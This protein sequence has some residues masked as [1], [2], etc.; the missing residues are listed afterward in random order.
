MIVN[1]VLEPVPDSSLPA[2]IAHRLPLGF[3]SAIRPIIDGSYDSSNDSAVA[4]DSGLPYALN[5]R[6]HERNKL[7]F[8]FGHDLAQQY[9]LDV[10]AVRLSN[11]Y[12]IPEIRSNGLV[13]HFKHL[14]PHEKLE[15]QLVKADYRKQRASANQLAPQLF[16]QGLEPEGYC[17]ELEELYVILVFADSGH[18]KGTVGEIFFALPSSFGSVVAFA[19]LSS[20]I[21]AHP[22]IHASTQEIVEPV[23]ADDDFDLPSTNQEIQTE[24]IS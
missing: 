17:E 12:Y 9:D 6:P 7:I 24:Q 10:Q 22:D 3:L 23:E 18:S 15:E 5:M 14:N 20:V 1:S 21:S 4:T 11:G 13:V 19:E 16:L 8:E 2:F